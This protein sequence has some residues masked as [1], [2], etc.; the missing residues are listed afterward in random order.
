MSTTAQEGNMVT[1]HYTGTLNDGNTF[2]SSEGRD[3]LQFQ[4]GNGQV[5]PG[6]ENGIIG[7]SEGEV[8]TIHLAS[9]Q[10]YGEVNPEALQ[11]VPKSR[12]PDDFAPVIGETVSGQTGD[13]RGFQAKIISEQ[14]DSLTLDFNHPL[15]GQD[16]TFKVELVSVA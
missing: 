9:D 12:F 2:D 13:G 7:M 11:E 14:D 4:I 3:P 1:V 8:K 6:F 10:A 5:I 15:A 16:L